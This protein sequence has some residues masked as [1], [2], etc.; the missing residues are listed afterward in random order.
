M[1][2]R[3]MTAREIMDEIDPLFTGHEE[4]AMERLQYFLE[5]PLAEYDEFELA[6]IAEAFNQLSDLLKGVVRAS[7][8]GWF[9]GKTVEETS[10]GVS[11]RWRQGNPDSTRLDT[12]KVRAAFPEKEYPSF[13]KPS[14]TGET[15]VITVKRR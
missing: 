6:R 11:L 3:K 8:I 4:P 10:K 12:G 5:E 1:A 13:Y 2:K 9:G 14:P 7:A 15:V